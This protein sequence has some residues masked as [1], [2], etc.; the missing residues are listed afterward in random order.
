MPYPP[1]SVNSP[2]LSLMVFA[3]GVFVGVGMV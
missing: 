2:A 1:K 3:G